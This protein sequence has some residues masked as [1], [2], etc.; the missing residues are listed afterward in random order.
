[1]IIHP[2]GI[3]LGLGIVTGIGV[4]QRAASHINKTLE[5][6]I[7]SLAVWVFVGGL[8][9]ARVYHLI[10]DWPSYRGASLLELAAVWNGG[11]GIFGAVVGAVIASVLFLWAK[12]KKLT[13]LPTYLDLI[14]L[15]LPLGQ[16]IGRWGNFVNQELYGLPT[17]LPWKIF[18]DVSHRFPG[19]ERIMYYHP[20]FL[21]ESLAMVVIW[22]VLWNYVGRHA[23]KTIGSGRVFAWYLVSYGVV[24]FFLD[25]LRL[26]APLIG[27]YTPAQW[28]SVSL[29]AVSGA[30][31][32]W[33]KSRKK[34]S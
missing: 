27:I 25:F 10:T 9:G 23:Y 1:M 26:E 19:Y 3:I 32:L 34:T 33:K 31:L 15:G 13:V 14:A 21:Y 24:R 12:K 16:A 4:A 11:L 7:E 20:L 5:K 2:Y 22:I 30:W 28:V 29:I 17:T 8:I 6:D 18:I